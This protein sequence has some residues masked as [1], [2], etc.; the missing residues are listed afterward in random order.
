MLEA[1]IGKE[2]ENGRGELS[3]P[4]ALGEED[5]V[6]VGYLKEFTDIGC[7][8]S[9]NAENTGVTADSPSAPS[10]IALN[11]FPR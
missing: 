10:I 3:C 4:A 1:T 7:S 11:S 2:I 6:V 9:Y 8:L 5:G